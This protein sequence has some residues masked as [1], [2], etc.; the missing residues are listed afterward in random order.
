M[1]SDVQNALGPEDRL[2]TDSAGAP[3]AVGLLVCGCPAACAWN[4]EI[5]DRARRWVIVAGKTVNT[6]ELTEDRLAEAVA[7]EIKAMKRSNER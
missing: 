2:T 3:Y 1:V 4:S 6:R 5:T 7:G